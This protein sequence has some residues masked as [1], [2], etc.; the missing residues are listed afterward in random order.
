MFLSNCHANIED[1]R[2]VNS[3]KRGEFE[4]CRKKDLTGRR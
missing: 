4:D 3:S 1:L 2:I